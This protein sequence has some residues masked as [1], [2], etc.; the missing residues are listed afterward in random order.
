MWKKLGREIFFCIAEVRV[1]MG[2]V[3]LRVGMV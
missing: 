3:E 1:G 2:A